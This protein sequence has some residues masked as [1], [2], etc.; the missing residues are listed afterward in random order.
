MEN[1]SI[2]IPEQASPGLPRPALNVGNPGRSSGRATGENEHS[3]RQRRKWSHADNAHVIECYYKSRPDERGYRKRMHDIWKQMHP[4]T[5]MTEQGLL[6]QKRSIVKN[7]LL[8]NMEIQEIANQVSQPTVGNNEVEDDNDSMPSS[9]DDDEVTTQEPNH[10]ISER[11]LTDEEQQLKQ[12]IVEYM[13][14]YATFENRVNIRKIRV[15]KETIK[16]IEQAEVVTRSIPTH[17]I[18]GV[19]TLIYSAAKA[20]E[21]RV[22]SEND[23]R[24]GRIPPWK[25]RL[26]KQI[27]ALRREVSQFK[28][29]MDSNGRLPHYM[30]RKYDM[31]IRDIDE[32]YEDAKQRLIA[33]SHRLKRYED[34]NE[35]FKIN[36][37]FQQNPKRVY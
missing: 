28:S 20:I 3:K 18:T 32:V 8:T 30:I 29:H 35:Q 5:T 16:L 1:Q 2:V 36:K 33:I 14:K 15:N 25:R 26:Q 9:Q 21:E 7:N 13:E 37:L 17:D 31:N 10:E 6:N 11:P 23:T 12:R 24:N 22:Y 19:N 4:E 27:E 34:R